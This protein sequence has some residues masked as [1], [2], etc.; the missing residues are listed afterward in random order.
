M[1]AMCTGYSPFRA[2][3][4][5]AVIRRVCDEPHKPIRDIEP[6]VPESLCAVID[7]LLAKDR[8]QRFSSAAV[9]AEV[10]RG[11]MDAAR[12]PRG[13]G[14]RHVLMEETLEVRRTPEPRANRACYFT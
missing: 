12:E 3:S 2:T 13:S 7:K 8:E 6:A 11:Q 14:V 5:M 1:Y 9:V 4:S 10:L